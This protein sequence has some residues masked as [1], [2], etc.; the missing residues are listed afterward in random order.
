MFLGRL[1]NAFLV[2]RPRA[3]IVSY[4]KIDPDCSSEEIGIAAQLAHAQGLAAQGETP[5]V[6]RSEDVRANPQGV[7]SALWQAWGLAEADHAFDWQSDVPKD[8]Q[9]V[10]GWHGKTMQSQ[11]IEPPDPNA[12]ENERRKFDAL[13]AQSPNAETYLAAHE[14]AYQALSDMA[15]RANA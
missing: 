13:A 1:R 14:P 4:H 7:M 11:G 5:L 10:E 9:Q 8:W 2:R 15:L 3:A 12:E 6:I